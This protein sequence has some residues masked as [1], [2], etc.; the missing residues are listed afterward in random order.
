M[1][2]LLIWW[3]LT[4]LGVGLSYQLLVANDGEDNNALSHWVSLQGDL[5]MYLFCAVFA[6]VV[7]GGVMCIWHWWYPG[8]FRLWPRAKWVDEIMNSKNES[9]PHCNCG[10]PK[11]Y[12]KSIRTGEYYWACNCDGCTVSDDTVNDLMNYH[13]EGCSHEQDSITFERQWK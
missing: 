4:G 11:V 8:H 7:V 5:F 9:I 6:F 3:M 12:I 13:S 10:Q 2:W 1:A